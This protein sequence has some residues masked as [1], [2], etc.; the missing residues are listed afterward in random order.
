MPLKQRHLLVGLVASLA[1]L[2][3]LGV[4]RRWRSDQ[5][6]SVTLRWNAPAPKAGVVVVGY[7]VYRRTE[8]SSSP[9]KIAERVPEPPYEDRL[10]TSG[11]TY[12]YTV[13][14]VDGSGRESRFSESITVTIP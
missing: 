7:N 2:G 5:P 13:T 6:H 8:E 9:V 14:S 3:A 12:V 1:L 4:A 10:V 11:E